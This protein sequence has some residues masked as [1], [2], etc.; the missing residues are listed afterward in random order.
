MWNEA[1]L[2]AE[3][4]NTLARVGM[5]LPSSAFVR[6]NSRLSSTLGRTIMEENLKTKNCRPIGF[7]FSKKMCELSTDDFI[8][9]IIRHEVAHWIV[10]TREKRLEG[11]SPYFKRVCAEIGCIEDNSRTKQHGNF[12]Y[13][14]ICETCGD[15]VGQYQRRSKTLKAAV[16]GRCR[17]LKC[18][19]DKFRVKENW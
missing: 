10:T 5:K 15:I 2:R 4:E 14:L 16:A 11:H 12:K 9:Q 1:K 3:I 13:D 6:I 18:N 17:C 8:V 19:G 7:E